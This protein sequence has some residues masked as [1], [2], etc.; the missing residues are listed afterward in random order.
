MIAATKHLFVVTV[1]DTR[2]SKW[3]IILK[4]VFTSR[5]D[6]VFV[7]T[8]NYQVCMLNLCIL[9]MSKSL[10]KDIN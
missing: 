10:Q 7:K 2:P 5:K 1:T 8:W 9:G 4:M 6:K 3:T